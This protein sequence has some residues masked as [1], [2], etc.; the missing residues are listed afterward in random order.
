MLLKLLAASSVALALACGLWLKSGE[1]WAARFDRGAILKEITLTLARDGLTPLEKIAF[2][3]N[4]APAALA[5]K[6]GDCRGVLLAA[7]LPRSAQSIGQIAPQ[8]ANAPSTGF[9]FEGEITAGH[10]TL[11]RLAARIGREVADLYR[12]NPAVAEPPVLAI[13][14]YGDCRLAEKAD[15]RAFDRAWRK[16]WE[17]PSS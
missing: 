16:S 9:V 7:P 14:E 5:F 12:R 4:G 6:R 8:L 1:T 2:R 13:A 11:G 17:E 10:P 15:W 3:I